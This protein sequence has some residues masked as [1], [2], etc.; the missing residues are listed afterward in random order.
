MTTKEQL[1]G[2]AEEA[3]GSLKPKEAEMFLV[4]VRELEMTEDGV[5]A[6][7]DQV[8]KGYRKQLIERLDPEKAQELRSRGFAINESL[9]DDTGERM[10]A[11]GSVH[12][13][14]NGQ[15]PVDHLGPFLQKVR[16]EAEG[17]AQQLTQ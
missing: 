12:D 4:A 2:R 10:G 5:I 17:G 15:A 13:V 3:A 1:I 7:I 11:I 6:N 9:I 8:T 16:S 14:L